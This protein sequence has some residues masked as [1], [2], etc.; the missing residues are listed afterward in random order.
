MS[1]V[2]RS[3]AQTLKKIEGKDP[4]PFEEKVIAMEPPRKGRP[5]RFHYKLD[6]KGRPQK[7][8]ITSPVRE[9]TA[10][11]ARTVFKTDNSTYSLENDQEK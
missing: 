4:A 3:M 6:E 5:F 8:R 7:E 9:I 1:N 2:L 10:K 11:E